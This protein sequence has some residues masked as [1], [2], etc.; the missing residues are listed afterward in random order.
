MAPR[1]L[2]VVVEVSVLLLQLDHQLLHRGVRAQAAD[3]KRRRNQQRLGD[4]TASSVTSNAVSLTLQRCALSRV[5]LSWTNY[6]ISSSTLARHVLLLH[7][8]CHHLQRAVQ[9]VL[10]LAQQPQAEHRRQSVRDRQVCDCRDE[11]HLLAMKPP[12]IWFMWGGVVQQGFKPFCNSKLTE[13]RFHAVCA[14]VEP[15]HAHSRV[16]CSADRRCHICVIAEAAG[17][18]LMPLLRC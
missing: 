16:P 5:H 12:Q 13:T 18:I 14:A 10:L 3:S 2:L 4:A 17:S 6:Q 7:P 8:V 15:M 9:P 11:P 1:W